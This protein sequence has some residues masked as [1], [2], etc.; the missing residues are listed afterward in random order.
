MN[1]PLPIFVGFFPKV[2]QPRPEWIRVDTITEIC[3]VS[4]DIS[5][6]PNNWIEEWKHNP[7]GFFDSEQIAFS[8]ISDVPEQYDMY[9][10]EMYPFHVLDGLASSVEID[11]QTGTVPPD[12]EFLGYDI[13]T[14]SAS[15]F[16][17]CSPLSCNRAAENFMTNSFC[18]LE[19]EAAA[20]DVL[21]EMSKP[22]S[23]VEPG[24]YF[25]FKVYRKG[26][27]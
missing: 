21:L 16:F 1:L 14:K 17:E 25:L 23:G 19:N 27:A 4:E 6:G 26:R 9:A 5:H 3:S 2:T 8:L 20:Y 11:L 12:Y 10:Y 13:V 7:L 22:G 24:P 15:D 18:L